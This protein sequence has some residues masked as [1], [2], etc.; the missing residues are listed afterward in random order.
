MEGNKSLRGLFGRYNKIDNN[1][2]C[3][4]LSFKL[5]KD[6]SQFYFF[7]YFVNVNYWVLFNGSFSPIN[8]SKNTNEMSIILSQFQLG[9]L[10]FSIPPSPSI[11]IEFF[12]H[13]INASGSCFLASGNY[14][15]SFFSQ[16][17]SQ[18]LVSRIFF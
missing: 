2:T 4:V 7:C 18:F 10:N 14:R 16:V 17:T 13:N 12:Y 11:M 8:K 5:V 6:L 1:T 9:K 15:T 3:L